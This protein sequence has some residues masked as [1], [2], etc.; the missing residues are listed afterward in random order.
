MVLHFQQVI[1]HPSQRGAPL[2]QGI[3]GNGE[4]K[5]EVGGVSP[6]EA[7]RGTACTLGG[8]R[9]FLACVCF[10]LG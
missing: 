10:S 9:V 3:L 2:G 4:I 6:L 7:P 8:V 5:R 1:L